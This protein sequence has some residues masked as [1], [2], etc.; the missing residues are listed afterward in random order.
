M[1][2]YGHWAENR[3]EAVAK[4][5]DKL[6]AGAETGEAADAIGECAS[7]DH[8]RMEPTGARKGVYYRWVFEWQACRIYVLNRATRS[9]TTP[10]IYVQFGSLALMRYGLDVLWDALQELLGALGFCFENEVISRIDPCV[11][12][13]GVGVP[14]FHKH[15]RNEE[16]ITRGHDCAEY[17]V[18]RVYTGMTLG[19]ERVKMRIYDKLREVRN[20]LLKLEVLKEKRWGGI[21]EKATRVEFE[22]NR[23]CLRD[24]WEITTMYDLRRKLP[25]L[26]EWLTTE[27]I[28]FTDGPVDRDNKNHQR[29]KTAPIWEKVKDAF[30][31]WVGQNS[32]PIV[33]P[34]KVIKPKIEQLVKQAA[35]CMKTALALSG[36][37]V[38]D[39][40]AFLWRCNSLLREFARDVWPDVETRRLELATAGFTILADE[41]ATP[42]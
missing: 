29:A 33:V 17:S 21:P 39:A 3:F 6:R 38:E 23:D 32:E 26:I 41:D 11:D 25:Q 27:W 34:R 10:S 24:R 37:A 9:E 8:I 19:G 22:I 1:A 42:I 28:R 15:W 30:S 31:Q 16:V 35:G 4:W 36:K 40:S 20:D 13:P 18:Q 2:V 7:G 12:L 14:E 5:F